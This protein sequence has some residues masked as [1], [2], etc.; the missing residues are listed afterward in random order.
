MEEASWQIRGM[1]VQ[2]VEGGLRMVRC[3]G[4]LLAIAGAETEDAGSSE[5]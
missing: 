1:V 4:H 2:A 5:L 3:L